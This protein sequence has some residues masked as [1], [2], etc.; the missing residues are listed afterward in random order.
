[1]VQWD[2]NENFTLLLKGEV[3]NYDTTGGIP[4]KATTL[5]PAHLALT[6]EVDPQ[7][8]TGFNYIA[9][10]PATDDPLF[11]GTFNDTNT[12]NV[13]LRMDWSIGAG[14]FTSITAYVGYDW[15]AK[16][17]NDWTNLN[18]V[19]GPQRQDYE[20]YTQE[21][22]FTSTTDGPFEYLVGAFFMTDDY[23]TRLQATLDLSQ[24]ALGGVFFSDRLGRNQQFAQENDSWAVF[25]EVIWNITD[26]FRARLGMRYTEDDKIADKRLW[27]S[28][29]STLDNAVPDPDIAASYNGVLGVEHDLRGVTRSTDDFNPALTL[30]WDVNEDLLT[31]VS[32]TEGFKAGGFD[33]DFT[34]GVIEEFEFEDE[35]VKAWAL[36][37]KWRFGGGRGFL[38]AEYFHSEFTNLQVSTFSV[39][40]FLVGNA[41]AATSEGLDLDG[42][43]Q[44]TDDF[45]IGAAAVFLDA[46]YDD[47]DTAPCPL[48]DAGNPTGEFC[49][50]TGQPLQY[51]PDFSASLYA[52]YFVPFSS[53]W[54]LRLYGD[55]VY[56]DEFFLAGDNDPDV[57]QDAY[58]KFNARISMISPDARYELAFIAKNVTDEITS[59]QGNDI[60]LA[61]LYGGKGLSSFLD[62]PR[63]LTLAATFNF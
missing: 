50:L 47:Y 10:M 55:M 37:A 63:T 6:Q 58:T 27:Y 25:G 9:S 22:R 18:V 24:S 49:D 35:S 40:S 21:L 29:A 52:D 26:T 45:A 48:D 28:D 16:T 36:G 7:A 60:P 54:T 17:N 2:P 56:S 59:H 8:I 12:Q 19:A 42:R 46:S 5:A 20:A 53:G 30:E 34:S 4:G 32:Y 15:E 23:N 62:P 44:F 43:W 11:T 57:V 39:A 1:M 61:G 41:A 31:Y 51:A 38:N 3:G 13:T 14:V 33:E